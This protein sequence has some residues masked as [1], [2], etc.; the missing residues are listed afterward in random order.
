[1]ITLSLAIVGSQER[2]KY[3]ANIVLFLALIDWPSSGDDIFRP[4][5]ILISQGRSQGEKHLAGDRPNDV[6]L[7]GMAYFR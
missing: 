2:S 7:S 3:F 4:C 5:V 1:M 6:W